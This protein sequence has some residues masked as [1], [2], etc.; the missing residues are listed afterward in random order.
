MTET[1]ILASGISKYYRI[2]AREARHGTVREVVAAAGR[3]ALDRIRRGRR[4]S[5]GPDSRDFWALMDVSFEIQRG[6]IVGI[7]GR[8]GA[9]KSTMLKVL[10]RITEPT[11]GFAEMHGRL[12][13][14][15]E[16]GTGF[17]PELTGRENVY[18]SGAILGMKKAEIT[19]KFD[20]IVD[21]AEVEEFIDTPVKYFSSGMYLRLAFSVAAHLE[22]EIL[23]IDEIL[24]VGDQRFQE[25]CLGMMH[26]TARSGR[27]VVF[28][29]HNMASIQQLCTRAI[30]LAG[31]RKVAEGSPADVIGQYF[32]E[33]R[34]SSSVSLEDWQDRS[35]NGEARI[36]ALAM[37][38]SGGTPVT[39]IPFG[40]TLRIAL[41]AWFSRPATDPTFGVIIQNAIGDPILDLR[42]IHSSLR[43]RVNG[44]VTVEV[45][46]DDLCLYPSQYWLSPWIADGPCKCD[47]DFVKCC[48]SL[49]ITPRP[50]EHGDLKLDSQWGKYWVPSR[51]ALVE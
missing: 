35:G 10:S 20:E 32:G 39:S 46:V 48:T 29:S 16:V 12:S 3:G 22:A 45:V 36:V 31:G 9:G 49:R 34:E 50:K 23:L 40:G 4:A 42:S 44:K 33:I 19:Q 25:K 26:R 37:T 13:S 8:N 30:L 27:T 41:S 51:W 5:N 1:V 18:L 2:G 17:Q 24:A 6:E 28:V 7:I 38:D 43:S 11:A 15:L 14:L 21:F 47:I